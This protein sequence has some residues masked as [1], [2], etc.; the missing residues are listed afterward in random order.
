MAQTPTP[1]PGTPAP[2]RY[3][4]QCMPPVALSILDLAPVSSG[5]TPADALH[6]SIALAGLA[7]QLGFSRYWVAEHHNMP[8][9]A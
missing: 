2:S 4:A 9:I 3:V 7:D 8:G 6:S 5:S 1:A